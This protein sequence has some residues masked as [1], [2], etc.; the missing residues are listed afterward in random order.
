MSALPFVM[1]DFDDPKQK[2]IYDRV[3]EASR[4]VYD[5]NEKLAQK[6]SKQIETTLSRKKLALIKE[7]NDLISRVYRLEF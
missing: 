5:A 2:T 3:V 4:E 6:P 1:L 7:I